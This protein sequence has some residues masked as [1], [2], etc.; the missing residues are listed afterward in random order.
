MNEHTATEVAVTHQN[1]SG[2]ITLR[3]VSKRYR[4]G[5]Q[6]D[7]L[8]LRTLSLNI[9]AGEYV[10]L[11]GKSGSGKSTL[12]N[13]IAGLDA[14]SEGEVV[15]AGT[16]LNALTET[17]RAYWRGTNVGVVFQFFQLLPTLTAAENL[18]MAMELVGKFEKSARRARALMLLDSVGIVDEADKLPAQMSGG[19]QQRVAIVRSLANDPQIILADEPTGNLDSQ[20][21]SAVTSLLSYCAA[22]GKTVLVVTHDVSLAARAD[23]VIEIRDGRVISDRYNPRDTPVVIPSQHDAH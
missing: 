8:A 2:S 9:N 14:C 18:M 6:V 13:L 4:I 5:G 21:A 12:L 15:I 11:L 19:Q 17:E 1:N 10:A 23:R 20:T 22:R 7:C 3:G 16:H